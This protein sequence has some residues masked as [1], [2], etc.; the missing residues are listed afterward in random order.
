[1][2]QANPDPLAGVF[3]GVT[4]E[5]DAP[6]SRAH[7]WRVSCEKLAPGGMISPIGESQQEHW[8][9]RARVGEH[10]PLNLLGLID[11]PASA[12]PLLLNP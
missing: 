6:A 1:V 11:N 8:V 12:Q 3:A 2:G 9:R 10:R 4:I 5:V 7:Q